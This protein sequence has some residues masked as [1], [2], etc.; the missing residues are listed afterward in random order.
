MYF[1]HFNV[2]ISCLYFQFVFIYE[3]LRDQSPVLGLGLSF[4]T[5][6]SAFVEI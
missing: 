2:I 3:G 6:V 4:V 1:G 5:E